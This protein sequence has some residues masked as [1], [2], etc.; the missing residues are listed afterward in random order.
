MT[1]QEYLIVGLGNPGSK[2]RDTRHNIGFLAVEAFARQNHMVFRKENKLLG[3]CAKGTFEI[4]KVYVLKPLTYM[5]LSG[6]SVRKCI[7]Y[8]KI[9]LM[10]V[11]IVT[12]DIYLPFS[13][14]KLKPKGSSG[15]HNGLAD[16]QRHMNSQNY[17]RLRIGVGHP[18]DSDMAD[19][20]LE[21]FSAKEQKDLPN[22]LDK[23]IS[24][25]ELWLR[26]GIEKAMNQTNVHPQ[27][28]KSLEEGDKGDNE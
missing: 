17:P 7:H 6:D 10:N 16:I 9:P 1:A 24:A 20:V 11:L 19:Y 12:D 22:V 26:N 23:A 28:T 18:A 27:K 25:M 15:G 4:G 5:N 13:S 2:Y 3:E 14:L 21:K 8:F